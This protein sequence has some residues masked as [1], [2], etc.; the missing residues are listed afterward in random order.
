MTTMRSCPASI[1]GACL[2]M[3]EGFA[4][5]R[6]KECNRT[7]ESCDFGTYDADGTPISECLRVDYEEVTMYDGG[8][9]RLCPAHRGWTVALGRGGA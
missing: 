6:P 3:S 2:E 8:V 5:C 1:S 9:V 4:P 7:P